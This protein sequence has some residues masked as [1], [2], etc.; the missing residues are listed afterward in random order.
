MSFGSFAMRSVIVGFGFFDGSSIR[1]VCV[2]PHC[3]FGVVLNKLCSLLLKHTTHLR[4]AFG[5][6]AL[7]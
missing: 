3:D 5:S 6:V 2:V 7:T 1:L 4:L